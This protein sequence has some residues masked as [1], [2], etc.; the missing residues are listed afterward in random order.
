MSKMNSLVHIL[1]Y[2]D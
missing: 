2:I 1:D